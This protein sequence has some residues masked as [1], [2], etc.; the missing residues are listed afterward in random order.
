MSSTGA[1][2]FASYIPL[3]VAV[4]DK[5][6]RA[7]LDGTLKAG[8]LLSEN[9]IAADFGVSRTPVREAL[10]V[11][12]REG[13]VTMLPGRKVIVSV[14]SP[15]DIEEIYDIRL[16]VETE[17]L[18]RIRPEHQ[19]TIAALER[20]V[21]EAEEAL[22]HGNIAELQRINTAFHMTLVAALDNERLRR[23]IDSVHDA[24]AR[25]RLYS[26][27]ERDWAQ[28]SEEEHKQ[29]VALLKQGNNEGAV[30]VSRRHLEKGAGIVRKMFSQRGMP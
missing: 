2:Q 21:A 10:R 20:C 29:I 28:D 30:Q 22:R 16:I 17:A 4:L 25:L 13:F 1:D 24:A 8:E 6:K 14:P 7:I 26:L 27:G 11:L 9:K 15:Q 19:D 23:F 5:L 12:E 18:R 3:R